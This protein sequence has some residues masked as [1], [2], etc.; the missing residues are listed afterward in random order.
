VLLLLELAEANN[1]GV[2]IEKS[3]FYLYICFELIQRGGK[4]E[5]N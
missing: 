3:W 5:K 4:K 2:A 1:G